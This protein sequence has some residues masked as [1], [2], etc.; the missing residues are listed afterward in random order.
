MAGPT[1]RN[2]LLRNHTAMSDDHLL[3]ARD[4]QGQSPKQFL[5]SSSK[6]SFL[7]R[8]GRKG[9]HLVGGPSVTPTYEVD[10]AASAASV[11]DMRRRHREREVTQLEG[12]RAGTSVSKKRLL[13]TDLLPRMPGLASGFTPPVHRLVN[14]QAQAA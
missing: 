12:E 14:T 8:E 5:K 2:R 11:T 6:N 13:S 1:K 4:G 7:H 10:S 3:Q 9:S